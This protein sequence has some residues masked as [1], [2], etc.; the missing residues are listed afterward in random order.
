MCCYTLQY[1]EVQFHLSSFSGPRSH[2]SEPTDVLHFVLLTVVSSQV[3]DYI[4]S[5]PNLLIRFIKDKD[6][7]YFFSNCLLYCFWKIIRCSK[8]KR[9]ATILFGKIKF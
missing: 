7:I 2:S 9:P 6:K 3:N 1:S 5:H 4:L 8:W